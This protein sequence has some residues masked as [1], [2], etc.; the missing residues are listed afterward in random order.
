MTP[1]DAVLDI[2]ER[3]GASQG[4][5]VLINEEEL[6][7]WPG[8]AVKALKSQKIIVKARPATSAICPGCEENCVMAV[9]TI[10]GGTDKQC[11]FIVCDKRNDTNR[12]PVAPE[13][14]I[15]WRCNGDL[16]CDFIAA[17]LDLRITKKQTDSAG[18]REIGIVRGEKRS[19]MLCLETSGM[20]TLVVGS[21]KIPLADLIKFDK[22]EYT[23]DTVSIQRLADSATTVDDR[24][25]PNK[26]RIE[27]RKLNTQ[28]MY[29]SWR[30]EYRALRRRRPGKS[31]KWYS[32]QIAKMEIAERRNTETIR[33]QMKK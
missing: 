2:M 6:L 14:L 7:G 10:G 21:G 15:Q 33:K 28:A 20:L 5:P 23:L 31:D 25:T 18:R 4:N 22:G 19:Q 12:V 24:Y 29:E 11:S 30:K 17:G 9:H 13:G 32:Q 1:I 16:V 8:A 27:A 3:V 26:A